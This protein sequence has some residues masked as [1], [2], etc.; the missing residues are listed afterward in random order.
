[1]CNDEKEGNRTEREKE[2]KNANTIGRKSER[3]Q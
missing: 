1:M 3:Y 2:Q